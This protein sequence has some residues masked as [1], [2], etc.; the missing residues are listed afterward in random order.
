MSNAGKGQPKVGDPG[1]IARLPRV[2][3]GEVQLSSVLFEGE[4]SKGSIRGK[5]FRKWWN[6]T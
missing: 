1:S 2:L 5:S 3:E 4:I 6:E